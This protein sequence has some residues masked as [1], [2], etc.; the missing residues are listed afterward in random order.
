MV[1]HGDGTVANGDTGALIAWQMALRAVERMIPQ[2]F[3]QNLMTNALPWSWNLQ[4]RWFRWLSGDAV[5]VISTD[6]R[7]EVRRLFE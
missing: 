7:Y 3:F 5:R 4:F 1:L 2:L 6:D